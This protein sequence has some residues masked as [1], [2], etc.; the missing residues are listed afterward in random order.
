MGSVSSMGS[1][2]CMGSALIHRARLLLLTT[3]MARSR[4]RPA[5]APLHHRLQSGTRSL[6]H[7]SSK[8]GSVRRCVFS[9]AA[10]GGTARTGGGASGAHGAKQ[11]RSERDAGKGEGL[12]E[13]H[14]TQDGSQEE[15]P[16]GKAAVQTG[17]DPRS[18]RGIAAWARCCEG[19][20]PH[21]A[22]VGACGVS[23]RACGQAQPSPEGPRKAALTVCGRACGVRRRTCT[24]CQTYHGVAPQGPPAKPGHD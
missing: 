22:A 8:R 21:E 20:G 19:A 12:Q 11:A 5:L 15:G 4:K 16:A 24:R 7:A 23:G 13:Q 9:A 6:E 18:K 1:V 14:G 3:P 2:S 17:R 10:P